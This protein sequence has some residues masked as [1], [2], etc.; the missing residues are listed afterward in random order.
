MEAAED[1]MEGCPS[2]SGAA[3]VKRE[4]VNVTLLED[5]IRDNILFHG[6]LDGTVSI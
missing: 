3:A 6:L 5:Q 1:A 4:K 2:G